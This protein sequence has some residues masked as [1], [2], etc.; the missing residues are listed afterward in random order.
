MIKKNDVTYE[1]VLVCCIE[2]DNVETLKYLLEDFN[3][4]LNMIVENTGLTMIHIAAQN[5]S[6]HCV[7]FLISKGAL[8]NSLD[9]TGKITPLHSAVKARKRSVDICELLLNNGVAHF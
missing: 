9:S 7:R 2:K 3:K 8:P 4:D 1:I 5:G 6:L